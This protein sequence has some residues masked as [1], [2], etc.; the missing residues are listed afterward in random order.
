MKSPAQLYAS[1]EAGG[2]K[3]S[4][5]FEPLP[6]SPLFPS[7]SSMLGK[8][9][10]MLLKQRDGITTPEF[11]AVTKSWRL[12]AYVHQLIHEYGW[13]VASL[14]VPFAG[15]PSRSISRYMIPEWV[16]D[17]VGVARG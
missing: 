6:F 1:G 7:P 17:E 9:L 13:P 16:R 12:S 5:L 10:S 15:D 11:Q 2:I 3:Q 4:E 14:E 8:A